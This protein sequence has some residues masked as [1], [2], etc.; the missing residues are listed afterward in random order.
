MISA[1]PPEPPIIH[2]DGFILRGLDYADLN[3]L[4]ETLSE[5]KVITWWMFGETISKR[6]DAESLIAKAGSSWEPGDVFYLAV[7]C[8]GRFSG[9]IHFTP[10]AEDNSLYSTGYIV[11]PWARNK[12]LAVKS[13]RKGLTW[14]F[15]E[16][17]AAKV[18][19]AVLIGNEASWNTAKRIGFNFTGT[20]TIDIDGEH[21][22]VWTGAL[23]RG[24]Y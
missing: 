13:M 8:E 14:L 4:H 20:S 19:G 5:S 2:G 1:H 23:W 3:D 17:G 21:V 18:I 16:T 24:V 12:G 9:L 10:Y 15:T 22:Q 7:E 11:S 6:E